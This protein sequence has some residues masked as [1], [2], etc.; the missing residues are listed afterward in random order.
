MF[1]RGGGPRSNPRALACLVLRD[2]ESA[3]LLR[4]LIKLSG[5]SLLLLLKRTDQRHAHGGERETFIMKYIYC[6]L[7]FIIKLGESRK[8]Q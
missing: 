2:S 4:S 6:L 3:Y 1:S 7:E 5:N 8:R